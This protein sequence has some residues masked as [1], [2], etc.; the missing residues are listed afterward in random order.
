MTLQ[1]DIAEDFASVQADWD[2]TIS[3]QTPTVSTSDSG[4]ETESLSAVV[5]VDGVWQPIEEIKR[6]QFEQR[7]SGLEGRPQWLV[8]VPLA[9]TVAIG[10]VATYLGEVGEV[11]VVDS[12]PA[13]K[14][15]ILKERK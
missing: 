11:M 10:D 6:N 15:L 9:T 12:Q 4:T 7:V 14:E 5:E 2:M 13:H 3:F 8:L 1:E